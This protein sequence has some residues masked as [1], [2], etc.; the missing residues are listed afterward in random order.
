MQTF[1]IVVVFLILCI[2]MFLVW[3]TLLKHY[4]LYVWCFFLYIVPNLCIFIF[5]LANKYLAEI[6]RKKILLNIT[7]LNHFGIYKSLLYKSSWKNEN[8]KKIFSTATKNCAYCWR[9]GKIHNKGFGKVS[10]V[11]TKAHFSNF[12]VEWQTFPGNENVCHWFLNR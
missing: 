4:I 1:F 5:I 11:C 6:L 8:K 10:N 2:F 9:E 3:N 7:V 12:E